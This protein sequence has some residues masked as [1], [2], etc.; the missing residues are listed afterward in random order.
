MALPAPAFKLVAFDSCADVL[1]GLKSAA[2]AV[3]TPWGFNGGMMSARRTASA[4]AA[5]D[6]AA[7]SV[8]E[9]AGVGF[10]GTNTQE[11]GVDE[12]DLVKTDGR[13]IVTV[14]GGMLRVLDPATRRMTGRLDLTAG[15]DE[16]LA[17]ASLLLSG[18]RALVLMSQGGPGRR[19]PAADVA[20]AQSKL[21][22]YGDLTFRLVTVDLAGTRPAVV[23]S[24]TIDGAL[25]DARQVGATARI[26][27]RSTPRLDF[28]FRENAT[29]AQRLAE[30]R[31]VIDRSTVDDWL[32]R[33]SSDSAS[34]HIDCGAVRKPD[35]FSGTS[36]L[37]VL[38][39]D[40]GAPLGTGDPTT[41]VADGN[42]VYGSGASLYVANDESW[43]GI[44]SD[45]GTAFVLPQDQETKIYR[46]DITGSGPPRFVASGSVPGT[47]LNQY[48]MS[49]YDGHLRV[50]TTRAS[51]SSVYVLR[52]TDMSKVGSVGGLGKNEQIYAVRFTGPVGYVV[53]FR[54][55][56]PLYTLDLHN[57]AS[58]AVAGELKIN[59]YS[60]YLHPIDA[61]HVI[62]VGQDADS[63]GRV[64]GTQVSVFDVSDLSSPR[65]V[66]QHVVKNGWSE[67]ESDPHAFL[68][69]PETGLL[70]VP[71][72]AQ[73]TYGALAL[74]LSGSRL[75]QLATVRHPTS[76]PWQG[77]IRRSLMVGG[78]LW[79]VS[80][81]GMR[82]TDTTSM[83]DAAWIPFT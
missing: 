38:S 77:S 42:F 21:L 8:P 15:T 32:P 29:E 57:P 27:V 74:R 78:T 58:P 3:V 22:S 19:F 39:F 83:R 80:D 45:F 68:Y 54:Q 12:P 69:W 76:T 20:T 53:T 71:L 52:S 70:V 10:S 72:S 11:T 62:G 35:T 46:F 26:V 67:A 6:Q 43:R 63:R 79:T 33:W 75:E 59:G 65:R 41:I 1:G 17:D 64:L 31:R 13:R 60:S 25:V 55:T 18:D 30:N 47:L 28:P 82:A 81:G 73:T 37:T 2:K 9:P 5:G 7:K 40:I 23:S 50:A 36:L 44:R 24:F 66:A 16:Y 49:E 56:D 14:T 51:S 34:G 61:N 4:F 48:A